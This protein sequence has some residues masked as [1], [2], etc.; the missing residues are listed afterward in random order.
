MLIRNLPG[1]NSASCQSRRHKTFKTRISSFFGVAE[2][3]AVRAYLLY[4]LVRDL[5]HLVR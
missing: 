5:W 4:H 2:F 3:L 1:R